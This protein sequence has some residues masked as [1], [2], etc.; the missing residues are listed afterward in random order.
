MKKTGEARAVVR[1]L[2]KA[3][4]TAQRARKGYIR[5]MGPYEAWESGQW[6]VIGLLQKRLARW[7]KA[8]R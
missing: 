7:R 1:E 4:Q 2:E 6:T 8:V 3:I 5:E